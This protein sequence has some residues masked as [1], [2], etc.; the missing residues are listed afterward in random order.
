MSPKAIDRMK[1]WYKWCKE[2]TE[3]DQ[4]EIYER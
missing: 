2:P 3:K 1:R 4:E